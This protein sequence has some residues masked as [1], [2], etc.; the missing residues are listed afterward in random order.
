LKQA[1]KI[2]TS[3][4]QEMLQDLSVAAAGEKQ[5]LVKEVQKLNDELRKVIEATAVE[6]QEIRDEVFIFY[7]TL[8][9]YCIVDQCK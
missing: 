1:C 9:L 2:A 3:E 4:K 6:K 8:L 5:E 7:I